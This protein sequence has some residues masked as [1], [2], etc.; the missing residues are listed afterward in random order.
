MSERD[1]SI[2]PDQARELIPRYFE[3]GNHEATAS[4][5]NALLSLQPNDA[6]AH[7][8]L[9]LIDCARG[10]FKTARD[11][12]EAAL[13]SD[14][15]RADIALEYAEAAFRFGDQGQAE[16][17]F[18]QIVKAMPTAWQA[19][20]GL[21]RIALV[22]AEH[23]IAEN[24]FK[25]ALEHQPGNLE[26]TIDL[27]Q[28]L[29]YQGKLDEAV[30]CC[31]R[32]LKTH[33]DSPKVLGHYLYVLKRACDFEAFE[34]NLPRLIEATRRA[35][36]E[37]APLPQR[38]FFYAVAID[39]PQLNLEVAQ[40]AAPGYARAE[41]LPPPAAAKR[42]QKIRL[43]YISARFGP[44]PSSLL[45]LRLFELHDRERFEVACYSGRQE[46]SH[47]YYQRIANDADRF[48][49]ISALDHRTAAQAIR[50]DGIDVLIHFDGYL[51]FNCVEVCAQRPAPIQIHYLGYPATTGAPYFD[52][53]IADQT[54]IPPDHARFYSERII[55][56]PNCYQINND[57][58][59]ISQQ[60][61]TRA[62]FGLPDD[63]FVF[64]CFNENYKLDGPSLDAWARIIDQ[65]PGSVLW[66][67]RRSE[68]SERNIRARLGQNGIGDER[69]IFS[70]TLD[71]AQHVKRLSLADLALDPLVCNGHTS[72]RDE[73]WAGVPV[74]TR[75]GNHFASRVAASIL[76]ALG[77][78]E[79]ISNNIEDYVESAITLGGDRAAHS[80][81]R[82]RI[83]ENRLTY[84]L[85]DTPGYVR[86]FERGLEK[87]WNHHL[88]GETPAYI[89]V[90]ATV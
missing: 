8:W 73:L 65:V 64:C 53:M 60:P 23:E 55:A 31:E 56:L 29:R 54:V 70:G 86:N 21:G 14:P 69:I 59:P 1:Q 71:T 76:K 82:A 37:Q 52:Y 30:E 89:E 43:G 41:P 34:H 2:S 75:L 15:K 26:A 74:L 24:A 78:D 10:A 85:F 61:M 62:D 22:R 32:A 84:P 35:I 33:P 7:R 63:A 28:C 27:I 66:L 20:F 50:D 19:H 47:P 25:T 46:T 67:W 40:A 13:S 44:S 87:V 3:A 42:R 68:I 58:Q 83:A 48:V 18:G 5:C 79:L 4:L 72:T 88:A 39:D 11:H 6:D 17:I 51:Q 57:Q 49:D 36:A 80:A 77:L 90:E 81:L 16:N 38:P 12:F 45:A 9:A